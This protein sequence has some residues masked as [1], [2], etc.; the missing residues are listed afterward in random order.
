[1][2]NKPKKA[3]FYVAFPVSHLTWESDYKMTNR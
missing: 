1:M 2:T 3:R